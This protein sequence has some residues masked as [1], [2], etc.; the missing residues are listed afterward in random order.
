MSPD[1]PA[2]EEHPSTTPPPW[3]IPWTGF[4]VLA[5]CGG[6]HFYVFP[7]LMEAIQRDLAATLTQVTATIFVWGV[8]GA[9]VSPPVGAAIARFGPRRMVLVGTVLQALAF[10]IVATAS[11]LVQLY[12]GFALAA[13]AL[14][15]NTYIAISAAVADA[16]VAQLGKA[17]GVAMLGLGVGGLLVPNITQRLAFL[18]WQNVYW[19]YAVTVFAMLPLIWLGLAEVSSGEAAP[20]AS[21]D[22]PAVS[23]GSAPSAPLLG[24]GGLL[25]NRSFW[26]LALGDGLT[27]LIFSFFTVHFVALSIESGVAAGTAALL[28]GVFLF[29]GSPGTFV[30]GALA[31]RHP[32][33]L[34]TLICYSLPVLLVPALFGLPNL[35]FLGLFA[36]VPG[37]LAGGRAAIFPLAIAYCFG[38]ANTARAY[39][40]LNVAFLLGTATGPLFSGVLHD[41]SGTYESSIWAAWLVGGLS[42]ALIAL[43]RREP[44]WAL[45]SGAEPRR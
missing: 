24:A 21:E 4:A 1:P 10:A 23:A 13:L 20:A 40:W 33:R 5:V 45:P 14:C 3:R 39:G 15:A 16:F 37:F 18:G 7:V 12:A 11:T 19:I 29:L 22:S 41:R 8:V 25:R 32:V 42:V 38:S 36:L 26:A 30:I 17:M 35:F 2:V 44:G 43:I 34:L 31:D 6:T 9:I 27:G 28:F